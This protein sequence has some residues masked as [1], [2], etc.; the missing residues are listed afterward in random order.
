MGAS[1]DLT[2]AIQLS[3]GDLISAY[4]LDLVEVADDNVLLRGST[5]AIDFFVDRD[6]VNMVY[7][8]TTDR[9]AK[10]YNLFLYLRAR[11]GDQLVFLKNMPCDYSCRLVGSL[12]WQFG[13]AFKNGGTRHSGGF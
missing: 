9:P 13:A 3:M 1:A 8:E 6:G 11:R 5:Y 2:V 4:D 7:V 12:R 10:A